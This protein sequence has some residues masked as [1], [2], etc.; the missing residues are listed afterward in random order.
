MECLPNLVLKGD[1][2]GMKAVADMTNFMVN[3]MARFIEHAVGRGRG[4]RSHDA[5]ILKLGE[6]GD[7]PT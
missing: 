2:F 7:K 1:L 3:F 4:A 6:A 5:M